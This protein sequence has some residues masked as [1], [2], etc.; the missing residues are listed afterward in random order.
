MVI[1]EERERKIELAN[2]EIKINFSFKQK[3]YYLIIFFF[4]ITKKILKKR[5]I[6]ISLPFFLNQ[7]FYDKLNKNFIKFEI[8]DYIDA[9]MVAQIFYSEDY[10]LEKFQRNNEVVQYYKNILKQNLK[11]LIVDCGAHIGLATKY[12]SLI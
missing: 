1:E 4:N 8:R 6:P 9:T 11:P 5:F 2:D 3:I 7:I 12:F 10:S